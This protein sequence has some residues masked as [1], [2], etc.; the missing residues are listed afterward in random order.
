MGSLVAGDAQQHAVVGV[1]AEALHLGR[2]LGALEW[3]DVVAV[4]TGTDVTVA[5]A[6]LAKGSGSLPHH[7]L[8]VH[9]SAV[10]QHPHVLRAVARFLLT[11]HILSV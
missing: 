11:T 9:P 1:V 3:N 6:P 2:G 10:V 5:L 4:D 8:G 7:A